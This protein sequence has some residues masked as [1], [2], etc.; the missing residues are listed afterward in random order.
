MS[1]SV[2]FVTEEEEIP[3]TTTE[4]EDVAFQYFRPVAEHVLTPV[5]SQL[6]IQQ[7]EA[8]AIL[9]SPAFTD[10]TTSVS[11]VETLL[12]R[13]LDDLNSGRLTN[14]EIMKLA[15]YSMDILQTREA[16]AQKQAVIMEAF[17]GDMEGPFIVSSSSS[18]LAKQMVDF[19]LGKILDDIKS[20]KIVPAD[21]AGLTATVLGE[22][23]G[24]AVEGLSE[25]ELD[26][27]IDETIQ[28]CVSRAQ[29]SREDSPV[30][31]ALL[32]DFMDTT[33]KRAQDSREDSPVCDALLDDFMDT[34]LKRAQDSREDSPVCDALLDDF[35]ETTLKRAQD[36]REDSP[37]CD[38]LLDDFMVTTLKNLIHDLEQ[39]VLKKA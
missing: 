28:V 24:E 11:F 15:S 34:T 10:R 33:L 30:C 22:P 9:G 6:E 13:L 4:D 35:M 36:S 20:G 3:V 25:T 32:D 27:F 37:V 21:M 12:L 14:E 29:D 19:T 38:A 39:E 1:R 23:S 26:D 18:I 8:E 7:M 2:R 31:D 17:E 16:D 5:A